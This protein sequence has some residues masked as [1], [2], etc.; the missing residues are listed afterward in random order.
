MQKT[1]ATRCYV[2]DSVSKI[3]EKEEEEK[4][5]YNKEEKGDEEEDE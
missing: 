1:Q 2:W 5:E 4:E 3:E